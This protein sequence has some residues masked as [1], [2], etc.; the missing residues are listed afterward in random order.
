ML[1][2]SAA[3]ALAAVC[4][5][6]GVAQA[7]R[8]SGSGQPFSR[9]WLVQLAEAA[10]KKP[11]DASIPKL[12]SFI[13]KLDYDAYRDVRFRADQALWREQNLPFTAQFFHLGSVYKRPAHVYEVADG[14]AREVLYETSLFDYGK[15]KFDEVVPDTL[16][17]AGFRLHTALNRPDY[18]DELVSFLGASYFRSVGRGQI[19]GLSARGLAIDTGV[20]TG[21]EFP[22]FRDFFVERPR[23]GASQINVHALLDSRSLTGAFSFAITPGK[24]TVMDVTAAL[25]SR[26]KVERL[27][28]APLTSMFLHGNTT[29]PRED[30]RPSVHDSDGLQ[31][32]GS[33]GEWLWRPLANPKRLQLSLYAEPNVRGF[34]LLQRDRDFRD[35]QD[36]EAHYERRPSVWVEPVSGF[37][38]GSVW[39]VEIP[40]DA[41]I[42][43]NVV[44]FWM[45]SKQPEPGQRLDLA[46]RLHWGEPPHRPPLATVAA[47]RLGRGGFA[48]R[49]ADGL[50][51]FVIDFRGSSLEKVT[52]AKQ[53]E[54]VITVSEG[55][56]A[57]VEVQRLP[58]PGGWR[59]Y[60]DFR[61]EGSRPQELR[62]YLKSGAE[63]LTEI[64]SFQWTG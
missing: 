54:P 27:G 44:A 34:G 41:E 15:N 62:A 8:V 16:G 56:T 47:T 28:L 14:V 11:L 7:A 52:E 63:A 55:K 13:D 9:D 31:V 32:W 42:H 36:L 51:K 23:P 43:D 26:R 35:Y 22:F 25:F 57:N 30:F 18:Q 2:G 38:A 19:Y 58:G 59:L 10:A 49:P 29:P 20:P 17:F 39:L 5:V 33:T 53:I 60:F 3:L 40:T 4:G 21:E 50:R 46:Y 12:P 48:G 61:S 24:T 45:P 1:S 37:G 64:W 6:P